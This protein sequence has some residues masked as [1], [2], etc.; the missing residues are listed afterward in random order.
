GFLPGRTRPL[1]PTPA[2]RPAVRTGDRLSRRIRQRACHGSGEPVGDAHE[3][4]ALP[5]AVERPRP[6]VEDAARA[7]VAGGAV[8]R[9]G[10]GK[11]AEIAV[12]GRQPRADYVGTCE[13]TTRTHAEPDRSHSDEDRHANSTHEFPLSSYWFTQAPCPR[14]KQACQKEASIPILSSRDE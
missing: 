4:V 8:Q 2:L 13:R 9:A 11:R 5:R 12:E 14:A 7:E 10:S 3:R 6:Q 1:R